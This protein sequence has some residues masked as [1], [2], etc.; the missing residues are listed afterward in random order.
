MLILIV[1]LALEVIGIWATLRLRQET[2]CPI[3]AKIALSMM[4]LTPAFLLFVLSV[5]KGPFYALDAYVVGLYIL[6]NVE[7]AL[8]KRRKRSEERTEQERNAQYKERMDRRL[9]S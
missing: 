9:D 6:A 4:Y 2:N 3:R 7:V 1:C 5:R 8:E